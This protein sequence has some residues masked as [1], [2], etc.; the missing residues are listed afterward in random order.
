MNRIKI[1]GLLSILVCNSFLSVAQRHN[2]TFFF[3]ESELGLDEISYEGTSFANPR[4]I[5]QGFCLIRPAIKTLG[6][7]NYT[8][9]GNFKKSTEYEGFSYAEGYGTETITGYVNGLGEIVISKYVG[10]K[11][12]G[13]YDGYGTLSFPKNKRWN[14]VEIGGYWKKGKYQNKQILTDV[15]SD[16]AYEV[17]YDYF[18]GGTNIRIQILNRY[19]KNNGSVEMDL[20]INWSGNINKKNSYNLQGTVLATKNGK[21]KFMIKKMNDTA[22]RY[23]ATKG[24]VKTALTLYDMYKT[25]KK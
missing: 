22:R 21:S 19:Y 8:W 2:V 1:I 16:A 9:K 11:K 17:I 15:A 13:Y 14:G 20:W 5:K 18:E 6:A 4:D 3:K 25:L 10:F 24:T 7:K 23:L 12:A